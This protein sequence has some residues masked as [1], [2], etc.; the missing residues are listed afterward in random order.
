MWM[1][2]ICDPCKW[3][4]RWLLPRPHPVSPA[5]TPSCWFKNS[6]SWCQKTGRFTVDIFLFLNRAFEMFFF[7]FWQDNK[8]KYSAEKMCVRWEGG[9]R[10]PVDSCNV[11]TLCHFYRVT[12]NAPLF[13]STLAAMTPCEADRVD[14]PAN[15]RVVRGSQ[16]HR[17]CAHQ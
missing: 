3:G 15:R 12:T 13:I 10:V 6:S 4:G 14:V 8:R 11:F 16:S 17:S 7:F 2:L 9:E 5:S 1:W